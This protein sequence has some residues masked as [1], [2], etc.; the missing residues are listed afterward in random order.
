MEMILTAARAALNGLLEKCRKK[1]AAE[2]AENTRPA[3]AG[4]EKHQPRMSLPEENE[5]EYLEW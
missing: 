3:D 2:A 1:P 4:E 5:P